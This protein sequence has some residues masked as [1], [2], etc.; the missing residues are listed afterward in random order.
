[1]KIGDVVISLRHPFSEK[2]G[3][4]IDV[5]RNY[6]VPDTCSVSWEDGQVSSVWQSDVKV[7]IESR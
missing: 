4:V 3:V 2:Q 7:V 6:G 5:K 1:M